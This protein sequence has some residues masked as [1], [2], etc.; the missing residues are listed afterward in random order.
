MIARCYKPT[1]PSFEFYG[2][3]GVRVCARWKNSFA[4]FL[5]DLGER[6]D[7]MTLDRIDPFKNYSPAN[8][9]WSR[10]EDQDANRRSNWYDDDLNPEAY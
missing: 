7:G 8:C 3:K 2:A 9:K 6:P 1:S 10:R 4:N 5:A